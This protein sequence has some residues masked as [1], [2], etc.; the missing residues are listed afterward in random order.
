MMH[1]LPYFPTKG[2]LMLSLHTPSKMAATFILFPRSHIMLLSLKLYLQGLKSEGGEHSCFAEASGGGNKGLQMESQ[3]ESTWPLMST[4]VSSFSA[5]KSSNNSMLQSD[6]PQHSFLSTEYGSGEAVKEEGQPL[7]S[8]FNEWPKSRE[9]WS[10]LEDERSNQI[11]FSTTQLS[12]S[13]PMSSSDF[14][15]TSSQSPHDN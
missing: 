3:L 2:C 8:F 9:S 11:A 14:S 7:R 6:Y 1:F 4:R 5:S 12:I 13:I 15:A 10:G